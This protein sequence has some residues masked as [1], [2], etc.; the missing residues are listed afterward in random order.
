MPAIDQCEPQVIRAL[1]KQGWIVT[2]RPFA[3]RLGKGESIY[4][5]LRLV[6]AQDQRVII[7]VEVKCFSEKRSILDEFYHAVGQYLFYRDVLV[8]KNINTPIYLSVPLNIY[9]TFFNRETVKTVVQNAQIKVIVVDLENE[10]V[11]SWLE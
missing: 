6:S 11:V 9:D 2:R 8:L 3:I 10:E 4:A 5:D 7:V 1:Q